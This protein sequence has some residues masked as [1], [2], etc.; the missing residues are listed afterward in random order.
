MVA[1]D[2]ACFPG[3][4][5]VSDRPDRRLR[6]VPPRR[7]EDRRAQ[8]LTDIFRTTWEYAV[9]GQAQLVAAMQQIIAA[10]ALLGD[11]DELSDA[12]AEVRFL[13]VGGARCLQLMLGE[14]EQ[15]QSGLPNDAPADDEPPL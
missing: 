12:V 2:L 1:D 6:A 9:N 7:A 15:L 3:G 4:A 11:P 14:L 8:T 5:A 10:Y 13:V